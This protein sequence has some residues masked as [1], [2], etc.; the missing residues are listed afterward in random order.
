MRA[1]YTDDPIVMS[2]DDG[3]GLVGSCVDELAVHAVKG[4]GCACANF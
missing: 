4:A 1:E 3:I 2:P